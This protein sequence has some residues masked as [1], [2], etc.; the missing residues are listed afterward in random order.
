VEVLQGSGDG[1]EQVGILV[2]Q[3]LTNS[4]VEGGYAISDRLGLVDGVRASAV[5][6]RLDELY[7]AHVVA[8]RLLTV[9]RVVLIGVLYFF[10]IWIYITALYGADGQL[11]S[12]PMDMRNTPF[13]HV[14]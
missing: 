11:L 6:F 12:W 10:L 9:L 14:G 7:R 1:T 8:D 2:Q 3:L 13:G 4:P 5:A